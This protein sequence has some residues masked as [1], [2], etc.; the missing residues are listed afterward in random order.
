MV[1]TRRSARCFT[2]FTSRCDAM[3][4]MLATK[5]TTGI[6]LVAVNTTP[7]IEALVNR[8]RIA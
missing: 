2:E 4:F 8:V 1:S 7:R 5:A 3:T 6:E